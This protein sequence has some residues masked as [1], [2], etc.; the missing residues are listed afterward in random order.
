M[1]R[2][3]YPA[4][5]AGL[6]ILRMIV[7]FVSDSYPLYKPF[8]GIA[9]YTQTI[10]RALT[11]RGHEVHVVVGSLGETF[12]TMDGGVHVHYRTVRWLPVIGSLLVGLGESLWLAKA[13]RELHRQ[14]GFD[15]VEFPNFEGHGL[16]TQ[17]LGFVPVV[18][19]LH[20]SMVEMVE[21]QHHRPSR[22][23]QFLMWAERQSARMALAVVTHSKAHRDRLAKTYNL[24]GVHLIPHG[25]SFPK[26]DRKH[27]SALSVLTIGHLTVRKGGATL[28]AAIPKVCAA[29]PE[30]TFV[31]VG[32]NEEEAA[33]RAFRAANPS[34]GSDRVACRGFVSEDDLNGLYASTTVYASASVYES[35]GLTFV[36]AMARG[37]P[38]VGCATSAMNE[39]ID[40]GQTGLL[41]PP[42]DPAAF[43]DAIIRLLRDPAK[44]EAMGK[45]GRQKVLEKYTV[46]R[47]AVS[48]EGWY[49]KVLV[50]SSS[51]RFTNVQ[52][53]LIDAKKLRRG[54][55]HVVSSL[56]RPFFGG[57]GAIVV[58]HRV[59][60]AAELSVFPEN[61]ALEITPGQLHDILGWVRGTSLEAITLDEVPARL[62]APTGRKFICFTFDDGYRDNL[63]HALPVFREFDVPFT[64]N[65][66]NGFIDGTMSVWW[67]FLEQAVTAGRELCFEWEGQ[68]LEFL[69]DTPAAQARTFDDLAT[70]LRG[71]GMKRDDLVNRI[72]AAVGIDPLECTRRISMTWDEVRQ[73][74]SDPLVTIGAHTQGHHS[75][76]RLTDQE[77]RAEVHDARRQLEA[78]IGRAVRHFAYPFGGRSAVNEREFRIAKECGFTTMLTTRLANLFAEHATMLDRLPRLVV[79][80]NYP[81]VSNLR[82]LESG[83]ASAWQWRFKRL[84]TT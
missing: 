63:V 50:Q 67:Y 14:H 77:I 34:L 64:V 59:I 47:M 43:A 52:E 61:S 15:L 74:A 9:V 81:A 56:V 39:I 76:N 54:A 31:L 58:M 5:D 41:V 73:L 80:G 3:F 35:F 27:H 4:V 48:V 7:C 16:V 11:A 51:R 79:S 21:V 65:I 25:I 19:R 38:V 72:A 32:A 6:F 1:N 62:A 69:T 46:E 10:A 55:A 44:C 17:W 45:Q 24:P 78:Q 37:V 53:G 18:V 13:L 23:E 57:A 40:D 82:M 71:L 29:V 84:V 49:K 60:P 30:V 26:T 36:E 70:L 20:T 28:L 8:G 66:T 75:L 2:A 22:G 42:E 83:L 33:V 68:K 12:D